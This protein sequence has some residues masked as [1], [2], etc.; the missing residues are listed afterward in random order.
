[1][2]GRHRPIRIK[3]VNLQPSRIYFRCQVTDSTDNIFYSQADHDDRKQ[4]GDIIQNTYQDAFYR[5]PD[6]ISD[7]VGELFSLREDREEDRDRQHQ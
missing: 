6:V 4:V 5:I 7:L 2:V 1:M 3:A